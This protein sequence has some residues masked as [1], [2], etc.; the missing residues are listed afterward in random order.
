[1]TIEVLS[2]IEKNVLLTS[3]TRSKNE[4]ELMKIEK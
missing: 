3:L 1:M 4:E 2:L